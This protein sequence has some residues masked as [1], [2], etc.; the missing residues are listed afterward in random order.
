[1]R[2]PGPTPSTF[3]LWPTK[4]EESMR[5]MM[6][7]MTIHTLKERNQPEDWCKLLFCFIHGL[8]VRED[9]KI[10]HVMQISRWMEKH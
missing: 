6:M 8:A 4:D 7:M 5:K 9:G 3:I 10:Y 2:L 1:M